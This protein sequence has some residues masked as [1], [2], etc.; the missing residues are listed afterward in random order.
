MVKVWTVG[1]T[2]H[3]E[4]SEVQNHISSINPITFLFIFFYLVTLP[5]LDIT[6][7]GISWAVCGSC[8]PVSIQGVRWRQSTSV[9]STACEIVPHHVSRTAGG[10]GG[11][12]I[13]NEGDAIASGVVPVSVGTH[14]IPT[15]AFVQVSIRACNKTSGGRTR[16]EI[17]NNQ[18]RKEVQRALW[19]RMIS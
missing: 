9:H 7:E 4:Q 13:S 8:L 16:N 19:Y 14:P 18:Y 15:A 5:C 2:I 6:V 10:E 1:T 3:S 11:G 17:A 12:I